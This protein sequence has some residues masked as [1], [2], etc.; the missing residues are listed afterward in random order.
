M[1]CTSVLI[2]VSSGKPAEKHRFT[3]ANVLEKP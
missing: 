2:N 3:A 1:T